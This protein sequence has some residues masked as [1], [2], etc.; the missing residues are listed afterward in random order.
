MSVAYIAGNFLLRLAVESLEQSPT[1]HIVEALS[2]GCK[3]YG[4]LM[5]QTCEHFVVS[6]HVDW[7][8]LAL[9]CQ[10]R[11]FY[12]RT[13]AHLVDIINSNSII[14]QCP[15]ALCHH[16][17]HVGVAYKWEVDRSIGTVVHC[18]VHIAFR[19]E[20]APQVAVVVLVDTDYAVAVVK[21]LCWQNEFAWSHLVLIPSQIAAVRSDERCGHTWVAVGIHLLQFLLVRSVGSHFRSL[22]SRVEYLLLCSVVGFIVF[23][24]GVVLEEFLPAELASVLPLVRVGECCSYHHV[25]PART[26]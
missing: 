18:T 3:F 7:A 15:L 12:R 4:T 23:G 17:Q 13:L 1:L 11:H 21:T 9:P 26:V 6:L 10:C 20:L 19:N 24:Y 8:V 2:L 5:A 25:V 14:V 16:Q 22:D